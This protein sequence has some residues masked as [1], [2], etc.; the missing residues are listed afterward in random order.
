MG[1]RTPVLKLLLE[2]GA[3]PT[4]AG[5]VGQTPLVAA[6]CPGDVEVVRLLLNH[7]S[8][9]TTTNNRSLSGRTALWVA[10]YR[11]SGGAVRALL[12]SGADPTTPDRAG[13]T[14]TAT[15][16]RDR[17]EGVTAEGRREC[18]A[19]L[20]VRCSLAPPH[21]HSVCFYRVAH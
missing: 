9:R 11:G 8:A 5:H 14:P 13:I 2:R 18:V 15:A 1:P 20:E 21:S 6:S 16:K 3:D 17:V 19:E 7:P 10:C 12:E 4:T